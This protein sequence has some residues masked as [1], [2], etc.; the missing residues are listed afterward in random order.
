VNL[1]VVISATIR[2]MTRRALCFLVLLMHTVSFVMLPLPL[3]AGQGSVQR[4][5][6][7]RSK[8]DGAQTCNCPCRYRGD[9]ICRCS[10]CK[11]GLICNCHS[12][13]GHEQPAFSTPVKDAMLP[14]LAALAPLVLVKRN[15]YPL[16]FRLKSAAREVP[17]PP[18]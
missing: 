15:D 13:S 17:T 12:S 18:P 2:G 16:P 1:I 5:E 6:Q 9:G 4:Q 7:A 14:S 10:R 8:N 3:T 11:R